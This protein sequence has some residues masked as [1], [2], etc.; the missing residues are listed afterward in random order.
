MKNGTTKL[1]TEGHLYDLIC[2]RKVLKHRNVGR[3]FPRTGTI[4]RR[5]EEEHKSMFAHLLDIKQL[6]D[7]EISAYMK[8]CCEKWLEQIYE[9]SC[10][11][12]SGLKTD[13]FLK[14]LLYKEL[15][16]SPKE[17]KYVYFYCTSGLLKIC[18]T[19]NYIA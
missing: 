18:N 10:N 11:I 7:L 17:K 3:T 1:E 14:Q 9:V 2:Y 6:I 5:P 13:L 19:I 4:S 8:A 12:L 15:C 16:K